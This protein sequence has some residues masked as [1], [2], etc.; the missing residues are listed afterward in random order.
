MSDSSCF[1]PE[2][3]PGIDDKRTAGGSGCTKSHVYRDYDDAKI[4]SDRQ[5]E[6]YKEVRSTC[7]V[8]VA[9]FEATRSEG[10]HTGVYSSS[11]SA[12]PGKLR[13]DN[14]RR[15]YDSSYLSLSSD[16]GN[17]T[18][19]RLTGNK[20]ATNPIIETILDDDANRDKATIRRQQ[21]KMRLMDY[22]ID[23]LKAQVRQYRTKC[24]KFR[25]LYKAAL[26]RDD[27]LWDVAN[28]SIVTGMIPNGDVKSD[29][30]D[31]NIQNT[32]E[33]KCNVDDYNP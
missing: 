24:L 20:M 7:D 9:S 25:R 28:D 4:A 2:L 19:C 33:Y 3:L 1:S 5:L 18:G 22:Q 6:M 8:E 29:S 12:D 21:K 26:N 16:N 31:D 15:S 27:K 17:E 14:R 32:V 11:T 23:V 10:I 30:E 13:K